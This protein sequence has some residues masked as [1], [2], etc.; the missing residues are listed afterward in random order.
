[1]TKW[2]VT[3]AKK[4][5]THIS[6]SK[7]LGSIFATASRLDHPTLMGG[8]GREHSVHEQHLNKEFQEFILSTVFLD[9]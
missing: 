9:N 8:A 6:A 5:W 3:R 2:Q 1:M 4:P 7:R